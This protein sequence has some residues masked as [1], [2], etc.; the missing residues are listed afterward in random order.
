MHG[1]IDA[2][3][4]DDIFDESVT[5]ADSGFETATARDISVSSEFGVASETK[6]T[7]MDE[8]NAAE[9]EESSKFTIR[10]VFHTT[11][12][13]HRLDVKYVCFRSV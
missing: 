10:F 6:S 3:D 13:H 2:V 4:G 9:G 11:T 7:Q 5:S 12:M 8:L 1:A